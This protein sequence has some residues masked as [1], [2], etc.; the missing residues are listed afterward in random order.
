MNHRQ[1][2]VSR[3]TRQEREC[4]DVDEAEEERVEFAD[5]LAEEPLV[6]DQRAQNEAHVEEGVDEADERQVGDQD[7]LAGAQLPVDGD[8]GED[9][10]V[11]GGGEND[12]GEEEDDARCAGDVGG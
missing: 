5:E 6:H 8:D 1:E 4:E 9:D 10:D 12:E 11:S 2:P 7:V 3:E